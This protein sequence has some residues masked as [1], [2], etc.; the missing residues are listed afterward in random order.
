MSY[1][2]GHIQADHPS[3]IKAYDYR[4]AESCCAYLIPHLQPHYSILDVGCG[5]GNITLGLAKLCPQG[6]TI[7][8]DISQGVIDHATSQYCSPD[9]PNLSFQVGDAG[10]LEQF[11]DDSFDVVHAHGCLLHVADKVQSLKAFLRVC[12]PGGIIAVRDAMSFGTIW[13][14]K[15]DLPG[16]REQWAKQREALLYMGSDPDTG[17][18]KKEWAVE[19]GYEKN[20]GRIFISQS[21]QCMEVALRN[22]EG[23]IAEGAINTGFLTREQVDR[24]KVSWDKWEGTEGH[25]LVCPATDMLCFKGLLGSE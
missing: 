8:I 9:V 21:P 16:I 13:S 11:S 7:G 4:T 14:L 1:T 23:E 22:F 24:F 10:S 2:S 20:G 15:P 5:P 19:A 17:L 18:K 3:V 6:K 12:K 25:E